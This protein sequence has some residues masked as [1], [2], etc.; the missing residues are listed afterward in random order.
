MSRYYY[1]LILINMIANI[2]S[3]VPT[4]LLH[5]GS[6]GAVSG[7]L[8]G[9][10]LGLAIVICFTKFF[11]AFPGKTFPEML[12]ET[13]AKWFYYPLLFFM[14]VLWFIAGV[15]TLITY[16]FMLIRYLTPDIPIMIIGLTLFV[17]IIFGCFMKT[18]RVL[19]AIEIVFLINFPLIIFIIIKAYTSKDLNWDFIKKSMLYIVQMPNINVVTSC[20]FLFLGVVNLVVFNRFFTH[21]QHF[22]L[23][24]VVVISFIAVSTIFTTYFIPIGF[25]GLKSID[26]LIY[27]WVATSD[28]MR[29]RYFLIERLVYV[30][31][32]LY[33]A[34]A[35]LSILIHWHVAVELFKFIFKLEKL[36]LKGINVGN[37]LLVA[38]FA[39]CSLYLIVTLT[40]YQLFQ[41]SIY[42]FNISSIIF[43]A[44]I[45]LFVYIARRLK[46][47][48][49]QADNN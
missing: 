44:K 16:T 27:P 39:V 20:I 15:S 6:D 48:G 24:Q 25:H 43:F 36:K 22:G 38:L 14:A 31:L 10:M 26:E 9:I 17:P 37:I 35:F 30:F 3:A 47:A 4:I 2:I 7:L 42:F 11:N 28:S 49:D 46:G 18:D 12:V 5:Y 32:L 1:Y 8:I 13:T 45:M 23:K 41:Y 21:K 19:Y 33:L 29:M 40:E 34:M